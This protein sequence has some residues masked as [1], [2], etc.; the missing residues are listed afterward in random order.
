MAAKKRGRPPAGAAG[1]KVSDRKITTVRLPDD[2][3][4]RLEALAFIQGRSISQVISD[5]LK[6]H[7]KSVPA[8]ELPLPADRLDERG[9]SLAGRWKRLDAV[10]FAP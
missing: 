1:E 4:L 5:A 8:V 10:L 7:L 3:R 9:N 2:E 6:L